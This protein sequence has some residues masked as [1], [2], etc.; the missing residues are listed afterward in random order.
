MAL[1]PNGKFLS[2]ATDR[3]N[4][5]VWDLKDPGRPRMIREAKDL[6]TT[7]QSLEFSAGGH[8]LVFGGYGDSVF[9]LDLLDNK[10]PE[11]IFLEGLSGVILGLAFSLDDRILAVAV[12]PIQGDTFRRFWRPGA[13]VLV[14]IEKPQVITEALRGHDSGVTA[15]AFSPDGMILST[16]GLD[17][18]VLLWNL[19]TCQARERICS[20][21]NRSFTDEEQ[22]QHS[23]G[24]SYLYACQI[25]PVARK[26]CP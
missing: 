22:K 3:K 17:R 21:V 18:K 23:I 9:R 13:V 11:A 16:G 20:V 12:T 26:E 1:S 8:W 2:V 14:D 10:E 24:G 19:N 25:Q 4:V 15:V 5:L 6:G 7:I